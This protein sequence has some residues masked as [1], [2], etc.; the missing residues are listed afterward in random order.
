MPETAPFIPFRFQVALFPGQG[1]GGQSMPASLL[2]AGAFSDVGGLE[3]TMTPRTIKEGGRN[4]GA[5]QRAGNT[6][7]GT[8]VLKRGVTSVDHLWVW[9]DVVARRANY[10][11]RMT[12]RID[13]V[14]AVENGR[15]RTL[16][17]WWV[18][19]AM[20][21]R[22]KAPDLSATASQVAVEE[23]Q[24]VHEGLTAEPRPAEGG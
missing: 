22:F 6:A 21:I 8:L 2:C 1:A 13:V 14:D 4:W 15:P 11:L 18:E 24:L 16:M 7:F 9:F 19:N 10:A 20:P 5:I 23:L 12:G 17:R 3:A